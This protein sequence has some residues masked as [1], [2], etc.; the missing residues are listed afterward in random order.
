MNIFSPM[1]SHSKS[2]NLESS[3]PFAL[4]AMEAEALPMVKGL[5]LKLDDPPI[6]A[7][8]APCLTYSGDDWGCRIHLVCFGKCKTTGMDNVGTV[9][10]ALMAYLALQAFKPDVIISA[11]TAGGFSSRG[12]KIADVYVSTATVNHDRRIPIPGFDVYGIGHHDALPT[13]VLRETLGLKAGVVSSGNSLDFTSEDMVRMVEHE[14]SVKEMEAAAIAWTASLFH[15]PFFCV[16][17]IT[18]IVDGDRPAADEFLEN[19]HKAA[20]ALQSVMPKVLE[21]IAGKKYSEL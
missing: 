14:A 13:P 15:C 7:P 16:K 1:E 12:A 11:G 21:F 2:Q 19:L 20:D 6:I 3:Q 17:A 8:P 18:D 9:P 10:A 5:G 4:A